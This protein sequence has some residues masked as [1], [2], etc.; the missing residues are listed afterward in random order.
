MPHVAVVRIW[1]DPLHLHR[2]YAR[3]DAEAAEEGAWLLGIPLQK[4]SA[5]LHVGRIAMTSTLTKKNGGQLLKKSCLLASSDNYA[6]S[7]LLR[8]TYGH[9]DVLRLPR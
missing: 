7:W 2:T 4:D 5:Y 9:H 6:H 1:R 3:T 8:L